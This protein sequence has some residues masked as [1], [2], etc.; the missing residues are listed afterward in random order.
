M[1]RFLHCVSPV[2]LLTVVLAGCS[3]RDIRKGTIALE[4]GDYT[5]AMHFFSRVI[6]R[7][8]ANAEARL[9][10]GKALLQQSS[11]IPGDSVSWRQAVMH[12]EAVRT[13][14]K[15]TE[16][17]PLLSQVWSER[18]VGLLRAGDTIRALESLTR[19]IAADPTCPEPLNLA[20]I[21]YFRMG[22]AAKARLLFERA[23]AVDSS[24]ASSLFNLGM[25][26]WEEEQIRDAHDL[27]L[28]ALKLSPQDEDFLYWFAV[29]EK[30]LRESTP[31]VGENS[32]GDN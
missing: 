31:V 11:D 7:N 10:M 6:E 16:I 26:C 3:S 18:A 20:G 2:L 17:G 19:S 28:R 1:T 25:L 24:S 22:R 30:R 21:I 29:A 15:N 12:L 14:G 8:P 27:W 9:G 13:L 32:G 4:L 5:L 23:I